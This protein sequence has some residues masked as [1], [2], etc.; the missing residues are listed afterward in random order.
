MHQKI[1]VLTDVSLNLVRLHIDIV[2]FTEWFLRDKNLHMSKI[3]LAY[4]RF[5]HRIYTS[6]CIPVIDLGT[7]PFQNV[8]GLCVCVWRFFSPIHCRE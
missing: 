5:G 2:K 4:S 6:H 8:V 3:A 7:T 1:T